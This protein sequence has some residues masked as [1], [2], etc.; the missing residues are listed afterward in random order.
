MELVDGEDLSQI[1]ARGPLPLDQAFPIA[2]QIAE[3]LEAAHEAGIIHRG[4]K[5][6]NRRQRRACSTTQ[7]SNAPRASRVKTSSFP[8]GDTTGASRGG[9]E[10]IVSGAPSEQNRPGSLLIV[11]NWRGL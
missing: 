10:F 6:A 2:R 5:P 1:V 9:Q 11:Q 7:R 8:S 3:A 4:L